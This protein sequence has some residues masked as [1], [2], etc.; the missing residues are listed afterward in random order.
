MI[1]KTLVR[2]IESTSGIIPINI[3]ADLTNNWLNLPF[4][5][6]INN[7]QPLH[8]KHLFKNKNVNEFIHDL[9]Y[10][11]K[12]FKPIALEDVLKYLRKNHRRPGN[13]IHLTFDDGYKEVY[14]IIAPILLR[15]G[16][17]ATFFLTSDFIDNKNLFFRNKISLLKESYSTKFEKDDKVN[18]QVLEF[19]KDHQIN[20]VSVF[21]GLDAIKYPQRQ[22]ADELSKL[23]DVDFPNYLRKVHPYLSSLHVNYLKQKGFTIGA[24]SIDHPVFETLNLEEQL[25]QTE[26]SVAI[27]K[28]K[29]SLDYG[30]FAFPFHDNGV[31]LE[32][33]QELHKRRVIDI[34][35]GTGGIIRDA[36]KFNLQRYCMENT[37]KSAEKIV[38]MNHIHKI[39]KQ[40][41]FKDTIIR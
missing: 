5:H 24:H 23:L 13:A 38:Y 17:P 21:N 29:F 2:A 7:Q 14:D 31:S 16:I 40:F 28:D 3:L 18:T 25:Y 10:F 11:L 6:L 22:L 39:L 1:R 27:I 32:F 8:T 4:Y 9:D 30:A 34:S 35:F 26:E 36:F 37:D 41:C 20:A 33:F 19:F 12:H 15:K